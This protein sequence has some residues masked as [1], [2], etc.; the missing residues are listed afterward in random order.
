MTDLGTPSNFSF[1]AAASINTSDQVVGSTSNFDQQSGQTIYGAF[2]YS[3]GVM[4]TLNTL[5]GFQSSNAIA[6]N[7]SGQVAG[8]STTADGTSHAFLYSGG[9]ITDLG[10]LSGFKDSAPRAIN[11]S[12]QVV[13]VATM[14]DGSEHAFLYNGSI[15]TDLNLTL[16]PGSGWILQEAT[17][18][19][20]SGQIAGTGLTGGQRHAFLL[21]PTTSTTNQI[22]IAGIIGQL[23]LNSRFL[24]GQTQPNPVSV[25][26]DW[27][28]TLPNSVDYIL[29]GQKSIVPANQ[30]G[31]IKTYDMGND[32]Q[33]GANVLQAIAHNASG[34]S[35]APRQVE[36]C[37]S[38]LPPWL[39][40]LLD[41]IG[42][43][44]AYDQGQNS[45]A[46]HFLFPPVAPNS[47]ITIAGQN[48]TLASPQLDLSM[49]IP[50][51]Q[52]SPGAIT[53]TISLGELSSE[54]AFPF[55]AVPGL[56]GYSVHAQGGVTGSGSINTNGCAIT[57]ASASF[58]PYATIAGEANVRIVPLLGFASN[59]LGPEVGVPVGLFVTAGQT[60]LGG[61][62]FSKALGVGYLGSTLTIQ[63]GVQ[64]TTPDLSTILWQI[65]NTDSLDGKI[66]YKEDKPYNLPLSLDVNMG[67]S[68]ELNF[69]DPTPVPLDQTVSHFTLSRASLSLAFGF[70]G[71]V[72][73]FNPQ[74]VNVLLPI[75][76]YGSSHAA[77]GHPIVVPGSAHSGWSILAPVG[78]PARFR[79]R[80][81]AQAFAP[82]PRQG[83]VAR[84]ARVRLALGAQTTMTTVIESNVLTYTTPS[85]AVDP[86]TGDALLAWNYEDPAQPLGQGFHILFNRWSAA[87]ST[88]SAPAPVISDTM[89]NENPQV[90]WTSGGKAVAVWE[91]VPTTMPVTATLDTTTTNQLEI[92]TSTYDA[93]SNTWSPE[94]QRAGP[95][96]GDLA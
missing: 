44:L 45:Y 64:A 1:S 95:G 74:A 63:G 4:T 11:T 57:T 47:N 7:A 86:G 9:T 79:G 31:A 52:T 49:A 29:N 38:T 54:G 18:I 21:T 61:D 19:N 37:S 34:A 13:G 33:A 81:G 84:D 89:I 30:N 17:A 3:H 28:G 91:R 59:A 85:L 93:A 36:I 68:G 71:Q 50:N 88:W 65:L 6:I 75:Y 26:V 83:T 69:K 76:T 78:T 67:L 23:P 2:V 32:L 24:H 60:F 25:G 14:A 80:S 35:S 48:L 90:A 40:S 62:E 94:P 77:L 43:G 16:P 10:T 51:D 27:K 70:S 82:S 46:M 22:N 20:D 87:S 8:F 66:G 5:S 39:V 41:G 72:W 96:P 56:F 58:Q 12:G 92:A 73:W 42:Q 15:M 53:G 55:P